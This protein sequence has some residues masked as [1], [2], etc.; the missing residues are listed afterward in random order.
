MADIQ[1]RDWLAGQAVTGMLVSRPPRERPVHDVSREDAGLAR[2]AYS[3][4]D[5]LLEAR[6]RT[7]VNAMIDG[8]PEPES[9]GGSGAP[10]DQAQ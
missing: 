2:R 8:L 7:K 9:D 1:L 10:H 5:A 4:A 6:T 3:I